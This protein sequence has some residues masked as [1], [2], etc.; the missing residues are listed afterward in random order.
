M[1]LDSLSFRISKCEN[2]IKDL[3]E[4]CSKMDRLQAEI[5]TKM[6]NLILE[7]GRMRQSVE[8]LE[9]RPAKT[10]EK[11]GFAIIGAVI[12]ALAS[13]IVNLVIA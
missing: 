9:D 2:D 1:D 7:V 6:D 13:I 10:A 8:S 3:Q 5:V 11:I 12:T 4:Q